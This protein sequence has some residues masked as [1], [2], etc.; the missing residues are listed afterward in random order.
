MYRRLVYIVFFILITAKV[1]GQNFSDFRTVDS[2][3]YSFY[4][5]QNW[6]S[7]IFTAKQGINNKVDYYYL[8]VRIGIAFYEKQKF[9]KAAYHF[10]KAIAFN[11]ME[12]FVFEYLYY[13]YV[14]GGMKAE[15]KALTASFSEALKEKLKVNRHNLI[16]ELYIEGG[17]T[18]GSND[19][20]KG[21]P[22]PNISNIILK[23]QELTNDVRYF[24][25]GVRHTLS[26]RIEFF[27]S[28]SAIDIGKTQH[29]EVYDGI[30]DNPY[31]IFQRQYY[32]A[33]SFYL[34]KGYSLKPAYHYLNVNYDKLIYSFD[35]DDKL[36]LEQ[37]SVNMNDFA[38]ALT[39]SKN[40]S[41]FTLDVNAT[42][43]KLNNSK[44]RQGTLA[45]T[46]FPLYN[47]NFYINTAYTWH[48]NDLLTPDNIFEFMAGGR[49]NSKLWAEGMITIGNL[50]NYAEKNAYIV[51]NITDAI[52]SRKG[53]NLKFQANP[54]IQ[55]ALYYT[56][57]TKR[58]IVNELDV[59]DNL[60]IRPRNNFINHSI[61]GGIKWTL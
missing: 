16:D 3:T 53:L 30:V 39:L 21:K 51:Y 37:Q 34:G 23:E 42:I 32:V 18:L 22:S 46:S 14:Y 28:A 33:P 54:H 24:A 38:A 49:I 8:R 50:Y 58:N 52:S 20:K 29:I 48:Q 41:L 35:D 36:F 17:P 19:L 47:L 2:L 1:S 13:S 12:D 43:A 4:E 10:K 61:I 60:I 55:F 59:N 57:I 31:R 26:K 6:D 44:V 5:Q 56:N 11:A 25:L 9:R 45:I 27:H 40:T 7:L 15:A